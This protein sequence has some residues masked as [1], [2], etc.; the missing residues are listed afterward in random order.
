MRRLF[1]AS[2]CGSLLLSVSVPVQAQNS[3]PAAP[4]SPLL[5]ST[6]SLF[7]PSWNMFQVSGRVSSVDGDPA[8]WQRYQDLRDGV[9]FTNAR[10]LRETNQWS[11]TAGADNLGYRDQRYFGTYERIGKFGV[12]GLWDQIPQ[13]YS[14][15]TRT[16][17]VS[18]GEAVLVLDDAAQRA[19][20]LN[21]YPPISP[22]FDLRER[23]DIGDFHVVATPTTSLDVTGNFKTTKHSGELP[24][25]ADFGF[26]NDNEVALPYNSRTN[27]FDMGASWTNA[28]SMIRAG[29]SGSWF[30]N[31]DDTLT[32]D[33]PLVL[34]D[35][36]TAPGHGRTALWP[37][38]SL[39]TLSTAGYAKL[40]QRTQVSG[41]LAFGW[42]NNDEALLPFTV[43]TALPQLALPR[44]TA[45]ASA[46]TVATNV[47]LVSRPRNDWRFGARFRRYDYNND[48]PETAIPQYVS[49]D[50]EVSETPTGGPDLIAHDRNTFDADAT[51]TGLRPLA[52]TVGY[53]NNHNGY[54]FRTFQS[55]NENVLQLKA[56]AVG[57]Q[58]ATFRANYEYSTRTGSGLDEQSLVDIGEQPAMR[59]YDLA[60]R[61]RN[62]FTGQVDVV[63][64]E[65][66][67]LSAGGGVG[68]DDFD[69]S[70][71]GLQEAAFRNVSLS[72]DYAFPR[73]LGV[74]ATYNYERYT[75]LQRSR[76][77]NPGAPAADP[78]RD[79]TADTR[80]TV[81]YVSIYVNPP[82]IGPNT[83]AR[84]S[85]DY[86][87]ARGNI[88][89]EVGPALPPPSQLP[90]TY[91]K[92]QDFRADVRH[93]LTGHLAATF[94]YV[95]EPLRIF[96]FAFDPSVI[97]S[98]VQPS[99]LVLGY[100][101][102]P[103][104]THS[105]VFGGLYYW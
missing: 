47:N 90:Q 102:R 52:F 78:N 58:W 2:V 71:F 15:D 65:A 99:S 12:S 25:G 94:S 33:N 32:W 30:N 87:N 16:P 64:T 18:A 13:F 28:K 51:W 77:A 1:L 3:Q 4:V 82:R 42:W 75:G 27:D 11:A 96:D 31:I 49:Y 10:L 67:T 26:S 95:Y 55:T 5:D 89:Y 45:E 29:Y 92:L 66:L 48:T 43:N 6:R 24:W 80:E 76:S 86:S 101:Y 7:E 70:Y 103:Y 91:N 62:R 40:A 83:E 61:T 53:T 37:S 105:F 36:T 100:T 93:R 57:S 23:R 21:V 84:L 56:D 69:D 34:N 60:N 35:S 20:N 46:H 39:Q 85:Y 79:W 98:I 74:G 41:S 68:T 8:R 44:A 9:L 59:H 38:N 22:Q 50:T 72:A 14:V 63:P 54:D 97:N 88:V 73:G 17:F 81:H 19:A 104:T